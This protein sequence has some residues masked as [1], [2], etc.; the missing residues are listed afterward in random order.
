MKDPEKGKAAPEKGKAAPAG[1]VLLLLFAIP[2]KEV[3]SLPSARVSIRALS[4]M[5]F[6]FSQRGSV[7]AG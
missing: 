1:E 3:N 5:L 6:M 2:K 7:R 4:P